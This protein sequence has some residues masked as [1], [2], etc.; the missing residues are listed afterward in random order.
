MVIDHS[1]K[2]HEYL[3]YL[4]TLWVNIFTVVSTF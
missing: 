4:D 2:N 1:V 3:I